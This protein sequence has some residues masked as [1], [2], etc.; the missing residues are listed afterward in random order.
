MFFFKNRK[1]MDGEKIGTFFAQTTTDGTPSE[2]LASNARQGS[3]RFCRSRFAMLLLRLVLRRDSLENP[4]P[5]HATGSTL[6]LG[7]LIFL[8]FVKFSKQPGGKQALGS[9]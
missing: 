4:L 8:N 3:R 7:E 6:G 9:I 1:I 5:Y 2:I